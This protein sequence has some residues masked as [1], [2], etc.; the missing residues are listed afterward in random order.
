MPY[1]FLIS[2]GGVGWDWVHLVRWPITGLLYQPRMIDDECG[3][4]GGTPI[5]RRTRNTRRKPA[6]VPLGPL[7]IPDDLTWDRT[8]VAAVERR[9][10]TAGTA[11]LHTVSFCNKTM[12]YTNRKGMRIPVGSRLQSSTCSH[13]AEAVQK[14]LISCIHPWYPPLSLSA[15]LSYL[16]AMMDNS[17]ASIKIKPEQYLFGEGLKWATPLPNT[18][19]RILTM[20]RKTSGDGSTEWLKYTEWETRRL[21]SGSLL[22]FPWQ[23]TQAASEIHFGACSSTYCTLWL[24]YLVSVT[25]FFGLVHT[26]TCD[27]NEVYLTN[28]ILNPAIDLWADHGGRAV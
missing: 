16:S 17:W 14:Q 5:G 22:Q 23:H 13:C 15:S 10:L 3:A 18:P 8:R 2:W 20:G 1:F 25:K 26:P 27:K 6:P 21:W 7:Q 28:Y 9:R 4:G 12:Y 11:L 24:S 19:S